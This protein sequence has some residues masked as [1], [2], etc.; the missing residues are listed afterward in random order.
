MLHSEGLCLRSGGNPRGCKVSENICCVAGWFCQEFARIRC[1]AQ[2]AAAL[3]FC[4]NLPT[5]FT[6]ACACFPEARQL[7]K[8][9]WQLKFS[10][11]QLVELLQLK[12][13]EFQWKYVFRPLEIWECFRTF[14]WLENAFCYLIFL[15]GQRPSSLEIYCTFGGP[16]SAWIREEF[17]CSETQSCVHL[18][19]I[20]VHTYIWKACHVDW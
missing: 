19:D 1:A 8:F 17:E 16:S 9:K 13:H 18:L 5:Y 10:K 7:K 3:F 6:S 20:Y 2:I 11:I 14:F 15:S 12:F 4:C